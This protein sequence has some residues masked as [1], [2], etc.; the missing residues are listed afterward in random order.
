MNLKRLFSNTLA[1]GVVAASLAAS[2]FAMADGHYEVNS[3]L[4]QVSFA[5]IKKQYVVEPATISQLSGQVKG[6]KV[7]INVPLSKIDTSN[8][9]RDMRLNDIFFQSASFPE[10]KISADLGD[11]DLNSPKIV[12]KD[13]KFTL[14]MYGAKK[15][16]STTVLVSSTGSQVLVTSIKPL[17]ISSDDFGIPGDNLTNLAKTVGGIAL[18]SKVPVNFA[19]TLD[20][21]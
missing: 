7:S 14:E 17:I 15:E 2:P 13:V 4:S 11:M 1:T 16:L 5:T 9:I 18:S 12:R 20:K 21:S 19:V 10:L 3:E 8:P 6:G